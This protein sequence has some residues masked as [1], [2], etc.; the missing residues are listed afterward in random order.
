MISKTN[1]GSHRQLFTQ[2][3]YIFSYLSL[4]NNKEEELRFF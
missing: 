3:L 1:V 4:A 2:F